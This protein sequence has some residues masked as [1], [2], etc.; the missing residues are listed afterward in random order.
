MMDFLSHVTYHAHFLLACE[1]ASQA[2]FFP[3]YF[4]SILNHFLKN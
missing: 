3:I 2:N 4:D 1:Q